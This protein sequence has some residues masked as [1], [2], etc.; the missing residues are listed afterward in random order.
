MSV[1][2]LDPG[3]FNVI[4]HSS[5][6]LLLII[7]NL[8]DFLGHLQRMFGLLDGSLRAAELISTVIAADTSTLILAAC[9]RRIAGTQL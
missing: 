9:Y 1:L 3:S 7:H 4:S 6:A 8:L 2:G 5:R